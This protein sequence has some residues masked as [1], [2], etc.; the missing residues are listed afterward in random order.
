MSPRA[1][2]SSVLLSG[3]GNQDAKY[4]G[5]THGSQRML[6]ALVS[7][8]KPACPTL[9][10]CTYTLPARWRS[11]S[12]LAGRDVALVPQS[13]VIVDASPVRI[14]TVGVEQLAFPRPGV[15]PR[16]RQRGYRQVGPPIGDSEVSEVDVPIE[17]AVVVDQRVGCARVAVADHELVDRR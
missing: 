9:V 8:R 13:P 17:A 3:N 4:A 15:V 16:Q 5:W 14:H 7:I 11:R 1:S 10:T 12:S 6:P 2:Q